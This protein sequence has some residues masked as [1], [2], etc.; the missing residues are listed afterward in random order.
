MTDEVLIVAANQ[1]DLSYPG[2]DAEIIYAIDITD[3]PNF[4]NVLRH[5]AN[6]SSDDFDRFGSEIAVDGKWVVIGAPGVDFAPGSGLIHL[7]NWD[8]GQAV[9]LNNPTPS[10]SDFFG[11]SVDIRGNKIIV[12]APGDDNSNGVNAGIV[13][14][15]QFNTTTGAINL[16]SRVDF[17][18]PNHNNTS[19]DGFGESIALSDS[20]V[21]VGAPREANLASTTERF[22]SYVFDHNGNIDQQLTLGFDLIS[23]NS[24][25]VG[26]SVAISP[27]TNAVV[28]SAP[29]DKVT[30][31]TNEGTVLVYSQTQPEKV[32]TVNSTS[33]L[34]DS[35]FLGDGSANAGGGLVTLRS[36]IE[37]SNNLFGESK[38]VL[39]AGTY[40]LSKNGMGTDDGDLDIIDDLIIEGAGAG[41]TIIDASN[42]S[43]ERVFDV[44]E[45]LDLTGVTVTGANTT[46]GANGISGGAI[47]VR[48]TGTL[49]LHESALTGN[50]AAGVGGAI[51]NAGTLKVTDSVITGNHSSGH[52]GGIRDVANATLHN[53]VVANNSSG[54]GSGPDLR[55]SF[56]SNGT[57][58]LTSTTGS[59]GLA[60]DYVGSVDYVV[61]EVAD[62]NDSTFNAHDLSLR[63]AVKQGNAA[64]G[65]KSIWLPAWQHRLELTGSGNNAGDLDI[66]G[67]IAIRGNGAGLSIID[68]SALTNERIFDV[69]DA[70]DLVGVTLTGADIT[71]GQNGTSG[72]AI[73]VRSS[74]TLDLQ[75]SAVSGNVAGG[76]GGGIYS[77]GI[78]TV[79]DSV[80]TNNHAGS[81]G[82]GI[83]ALGSATLS[84]TI[85]AK[86][87]SGI[88]SG[89]NVFGSFSSDGTNLLNTISGATGFGSDHVGAVSRVVTSLRDRLD[90]SDD[91]HSWTLRDA[92]HT[93]NAVSGADEIWLP[94]WVFKLTEENEGGDEDFAFTG[95]IDIRDTVTIRAAGSATID[96]SLIVDD[97][98]EQVGA[99]AL[100]LYGIT[101]VD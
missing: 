32:F 50:T 101:E 52:G 53:T 28:V 67:D 86:N 25:Q 74:G 37:E 40:M 82:G 11:Q 5:Y 79:T 19:S 15:Y 85:V 90:H 94:A 88:S 70:L 54:N 98:F 26:A 68:A 69:S 91:S 21:V 41:L 64:A 27:Q 56:S 87:S 100:T 65:A 57:N 36:A 29:E 20:S 8:T 51:Y 12:S 3:G 9:T 33:D 44:F 24:P 92:V 16:S 77:A 73:W 93:S 84:K 89:P 31:S 80:I 7:W 13:Y 39:P 22:R 61:T 71:S 42:L 38:I 6:L 96:A 10:Q 17:H 47:W 55:G 18:N 60:D 2:V 66:T 59:S 78:L 58:L 48:N 97:V 63:E 99:A 34:S 1:T 49:N 76:V 62:H 95:D 75:E 30:N 43:G 14:S 4:G 72:G 81:R 46:G 45:K 35:T 83:R 23:N